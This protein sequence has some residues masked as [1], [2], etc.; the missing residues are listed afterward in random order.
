MVQLPPLSKKNAEV[1]KALSYFLQCKEKI[2]WFPHNDEYGVDVY[3]V[4]GCLRL[5][6]PLRTRP[7]QWF[8]DWLGE[9]K[10]EIHLNREGPSFMNCADFVYLTLFKAGVIAKEKIKQRYLEQKG[11]YYGFP[12]VD[13]APFD[14][15]K[16]EAQSGDILLGY[17][18]G[19]PEH[20]M[21]LSGKDREGEWIAAGLW[22]MDGEVTFN[23]RH[24]PLESRLTKLQ[25]FCK[26]N[27]NQSLTFGWCPLEKIHF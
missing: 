17:V 16:G 4:K 10:A 25:L 22:N 12:L 21:I 13:F 19:I 15:K 1:V 9:D 11:T 8:L 18:N 5:K 2:V 24:S 7:K 26:N 23:L 14:P 27:G 20:V 6:V 3:E